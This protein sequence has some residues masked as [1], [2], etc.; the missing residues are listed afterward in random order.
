[1][2]TS[3]PIYEFLRVTTYT[4]MSQISIL[5]VH[6]V[7]FSQIFSFFRVLF[8]NGKILIEKFFFENDI[9]CLILFASENCL[10]EYLSVQFSRKTKLYKRL[11]SLLRAIKLLHI[12]KS[13]F[14]FQ[15]QNFTM[16]L[17]IIKKK[18]IFIIRRRF[19]KLM[20]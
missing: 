18:S 6:V 10:N 3:F 17:W 14:S 16:L 7:L 15:L 13:F 8:F 19:G 5:V 4:K 11:E 2:S 1:M 12:L 20:R 9:C